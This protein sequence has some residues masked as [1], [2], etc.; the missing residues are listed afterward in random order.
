MKRI[1]WMIIGSFS[2]PFLLNFIIWM[3]IL[4]MQFLWLY[5]DDLMGKGLEWN[6]ILE[7]MLYASANW[8]PL[9]LPL[10]VLLA[11]IMSFGSLGEKNE[12]LALKAA[13]FSLYK[14]MKP[15]IVVIFFIST[16][17]FYFTN[18]L[19]PIAHFKMRVLL[20]DIQN[21][22]VALALQPGVFFKTDN[23][24]IRIGS[25][26]NE[27][28][29]FNDILIYDHSNNSKQPLGSWSY[30]KD[31]RDFKRVIRAKKGKLI[32][33]EDKT[34]LDLELYEGYMVQEWDSKSFANSKNP[35][36]KY[37]FKQSVI[38][39]Q[40]NSFE[41]ERSSE[42]NYQRDNHL[43]N[44]SQ[45]NIKNDSLN[46]EIESN[47]NEIEKIL[48]NEF[49]LLQDTNKNATPTTKESKSFENKIHLIQNGQSIA[50]LRND[51]NLTI[52]K[53]SKISS[54]LNRYKKREAV[55]LNNK[56]DLIIEWNR[57]FTLSYAVFMLFFL[58]GPLGAIVKKGGL[59]WPVITAILI[60]LI[61]F[62]LT[63]AGEEMASNHNLGP[64]TGM[65]LSA[66]CI[67]PLSIFIFF[68]ANQDAKIFDIEWYKKLVL[69]IFK[70]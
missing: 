26:N 58:G 8:V 67:T 39:F 21:T 12:L 2:G 41:F 32:N 49:F 30:N 54:K 29:E 68:K 6:I 55:L 28:N 10:S 36:T 25:K 50:S 31:P 33:P 23:F 40:L 46:K 13:G 47:Y 7:L 69:K 56:S 24:A 59:G 19:W 9:A 60:F 43:L 11:S 65:W 3:V 62:M 5:I 20:R 35:F 63:R 17:A 52:K 61:Y 44:I 27:G 34:R 18:N 42:S 1:G 14:I 45:I 66:I 51:Q 16:F 57:K 4:D 48:I 64:N 37:H 70:K 53:L 15:L 38:S 22:K